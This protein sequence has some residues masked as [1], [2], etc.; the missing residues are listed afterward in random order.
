[1][2]RERM[3]PVL[4]PIELFK[5]FLSIFFTPCAFMPQKSK[6]N[7]SLVAEQ[8]LTRPLG[9]CLSLSLRPSFPLVAD[10]CIVPHFR[11]KIVAVG[12]VRKWGWDLQ[13][14]LFTLSPQSFC[15]V[16]KWNQLCFY[17]FLGEG[18]DAVCSVLKFSE[19]P[20]FILVELDA[21]SEKN[22]IACSLVCTRSLV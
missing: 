4:A 19:F 12:M 6:S 5:F 7:S 20:I 11:F 13:L 2:H 9:T 17:P 18:V 8:F 14:V 3:S 16:I 10:W 21:F 1:M 22:T 15:R